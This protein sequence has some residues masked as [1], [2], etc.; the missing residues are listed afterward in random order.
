M[1]KKPLTL[2]PEQA[3][4]YDTSIDKI[5]DSSSGSNAPGR[6]PAPY[7]APPDHIDQVKA[8]QE[9]HAYPGRFARDRILRDWD[10][11]YVECDFCGEWTRSG[12]CRCVRGA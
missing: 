7:L 4:Q 2:T 1:P 3:W 9:T 12:E 11:R 8:W 6:N 10:D 5:I